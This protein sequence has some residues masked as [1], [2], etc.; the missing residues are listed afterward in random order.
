MTGV[1]TDFTMR[2]T[3]PA[4]IFVLLW[5]E[6]IAAAPA[7]DP[8]T[9]ENSTVHTIYGVEEGNH[10]HSARV[11]RFSPFDVI[12]PAGQAA[13]ADFIERTK[14]QAN[15]QCR[16]HI[17][18]FITNV[19]NS[20]DVNFATTGG[21]NNWLNEKL[22]NGVVPGYTVDWDFENIRRGGYLRIVQIY[23]KGRSCIESFSISCGP[24]AIGRDMAAV[25]VNVE[26]MR[27]NWIQ[28]KGNPGLKEVWWKPSWGDDELSDDP[29]VWFE[30][31]DNVNNAFT[32]LDV[33]PAAFFCQQNDF[34]CVKNNIETF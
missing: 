8:E 27:Q 16:I 14:A 24:S 22:D 18:H 2:R 7:E 33:Y 31:G 32:A 30:R 26:H 34:D 20:F 19:H 6:S 13:F 4:M 17:R 9:G 1:Q 5:V 29:C 28:N 3:V 23:P 25:V 10:T 15:D 11:K 21:V 12:V